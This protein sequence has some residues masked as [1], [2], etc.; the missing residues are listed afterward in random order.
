VTPTPRPA[1]P[2]RLAERARPLAL[3]GERRLPLAPALVPLLGTD[4][5]RRGTTIV[6]T[7]ASGDRGRPGPDPVPGASAMALALAAGPS[8]AGSW[9]AAVGLPD[10]GVVAAT[11]MGADPERLL[12][13]DRPGPRWPDVVAALTVV[14][15]RAAGARPADARRLSARVRERGAV[16]VPLGDGW[17][18]PAELRLTVT[19]GIWHGLGAGHGHL[20]ARLADVQV[21]GRGSASRP[22]TG[23]LWLPGPGGVASLPAGP[24]AAAPAWPLDVPLAAGLGSTVLGDDAELAGAFGPS[25]AGARHRPVLGADD[26]AEAG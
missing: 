6:V 13:V 7:G 14:L 1:L 19:G 4:G 21:T 12:L 9:V 3:A 17:P 8:A 2:D 16:L 24:G 5:L 26:Q 15:V 20:R 11:E 25:R 10:L 22:R 23:R 18:E